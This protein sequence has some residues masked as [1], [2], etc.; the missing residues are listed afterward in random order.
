MFNFVSVLH[1]NFKWKNE[2]KVFNIT[3]KGRKQHETHQ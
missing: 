2:V 3:T 1:K